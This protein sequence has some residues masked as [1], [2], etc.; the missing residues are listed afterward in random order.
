M[1][2]SLAPRIPNLVIT[3]LT[4][5]KHLPTADNF[6]ELGLTLAIPDVLLRL[7]DRAQSGSQKHRVFLGKVLGIRDTNK[8]NK[9]FGN[10][11]AVARINI[12]VDTLRRQDR[13]YSISDKDII[14]EVAKSLEGSFERTSNYVSLSPKR[15]F[16]R[17]YFVKVLSFSL[18]ASAIIVTTSANFFTQVGQFISALQLRNEFNAIVTEKQDFTNQ[19]WKKAGGPFAKY[20]IGVLIAA[21]GIV[22]PQVSVAGLVLAFMDP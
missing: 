20:Y 12:L 6:I 19:F 10:P 16:V 1:N 15:N 18:R 2:P 4:D 5:L 21:A 22:S 14:P 17:D 11:E 7:L 3:G 13:L 9:E 8:T